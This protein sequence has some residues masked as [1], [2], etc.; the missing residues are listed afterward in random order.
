MV[1]EQSAPAG[2]A[3]EGAEGEAAPKPYEGNTVAVFFPDTGSAVWVDQ[4]WKVGQLGSK[5][6][7]SVRCASFPNEGLLPTDTVREPCPFAACSIPPM[8]HSILSLT[9]C[10]TLALNRSPPWWPAGLSDRVPA[11]VGECGDVRPGDVHP[12]GPARGAHQPRAHRCRGRRLR[13][14]YDTHIH[15]QPCP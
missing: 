3:A 9:G 8:M 2:E 11:C 13:H 1:M 14:G 10:A 4:D 7:P 12:R 5:V 6:P 15:M